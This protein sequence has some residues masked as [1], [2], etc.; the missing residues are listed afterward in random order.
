VRVTIR[1]E[2]N[3]YLFYEFGLDGE[4]DVSAVSENWPFVLETV[5]SLDTSDQHLEVFRFWDKEDEYYAI[6]GGRF[7]FLPTAG[8]DLDDLRNTFLGTQWI[9]NRGPVDLGTV[10]IGDPQ[11]PSGSARRAAIEELAKAAL[12]ANGFRIAEGLLLRA[13]GEYLALIIAEGSQGEAI[14]VGSNI[15]PRA[16]G[17]P[18]ASQHRR[19]SWAV[20]QLIREGV[21]SS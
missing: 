18:D 13:T 8:M 20:G 5:G 4:A 11:V 21:I 9:G 12:A 3:E 15:P 10:M 2:I 16:V 14:L 19:L 7:S 6:G 1:R 17:F